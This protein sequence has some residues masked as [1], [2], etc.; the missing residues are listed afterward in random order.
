MITRRFILMNA[1]QSF[2]LMLVP[3]HSFINRVYFRQLMPLQVPTGYSFSPYLA[4][5][6]CVHKFCTTDFGCCPIRRETET[7]TA[8]HPFLASH[9]LARPCHACLTWGSPPA[10]QRRNAFGRTSSYEVVCY[11]RS[12]E[13]GLIQAYCSGSGKTPTRS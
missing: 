12:L 2:G 13:L 1:T 6:N 4:S 5:F 10:T 7:E 8:I 9:V 11:T 3:S